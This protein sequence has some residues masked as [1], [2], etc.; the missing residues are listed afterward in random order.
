MTEEEL[1]KIFSRM[2][3]TAGDVLTWSM[4]IKSL[5]T[6]VRLGIGMKQRSTKP[7]FNPELRWIMKS[8][9]VN[10]LVYIH[11]YQ[12]VVVKLKIAP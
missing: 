5:S 7:I 4:Y 3:Q 2:V 8:G 6:T 1:D 9:Y 12:N 10:K 11:T